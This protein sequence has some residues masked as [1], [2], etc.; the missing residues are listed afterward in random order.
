M[1]ATATTAEPAEREPAE[2]EP[3]AELPAESGALATLAATLLGTAPAPPPGAAGLVHL[4]DG[5]AAPP[6]GR[7]RRRVRVCSRCATLTVRALCR[8]CRD[9]P[10]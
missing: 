5:T 6:R 9:A 3:S 8:R 4:L 7:P 1:S 10:A 2:R